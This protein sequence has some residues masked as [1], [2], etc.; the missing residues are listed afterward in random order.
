MQPLLLQDTS[1]LINLLATGRFDE[2]SKSTQWHFAI[3]DA[4]RGEAKSLWNPDTQQRE[5]I[6]LD[7]L[8][9]SGSLVVLDLDTDDEHDAHVRLCSLPGVGP[10][11]AMCMALAQ[12][13]QLE[14]ATDDRKA[15]RVC[16]AAQPAIQT[17][18]TPDVL[19][20]W[21]NAIGL[22]QREMGEL[23][24]RIEARARFSLIASHPHFAW[25]QAQKQA[26]I[27]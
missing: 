21:Q 6:A 16:L 18:S 11:E 20:R 4:V 19:I 12:S 22:S 8:I 23:I 2:I 25:W 15:N 1:V 5:S 14:F 10:G 13:R 7:P 3:C 26:A 24:L 9:Q 27:H 17:V